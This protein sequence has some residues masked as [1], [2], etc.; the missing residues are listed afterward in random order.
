MFS[1]IFNVLFLLL[2]NFEVKVSMRTLKYTFF[3][4]FGHSGKTKTHLVINYVLLALCYC[5]KYLQSKHWKTSSE[6]KK[7]FSV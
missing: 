5:S 7:C 1:N 6:K 4:L 2:F 3:C